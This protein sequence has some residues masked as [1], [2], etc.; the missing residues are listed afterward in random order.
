MGLSTSSARLLRPEP[1]DA[2][3]VATWSLSSDEAKRWWGSDGRLPEPADITAWW[4]SDDVVPWLL[5]DH[6]DRPVAYGELWLD[7]DEDEVE[8]AHLI[9]D[10]DRRRQGLGRLLVAGLVDAARGTGLASCFLRVRPDNAA[11]MGL[12]RSTGFVDFDEKRTAEWNLEQPVE[13]AWLEWPNR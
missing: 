13:Y 4:Q 12:Y 11:A 7:A 3:I 9:V 5:V 8:L 6:D 1:S 10:P 2:P